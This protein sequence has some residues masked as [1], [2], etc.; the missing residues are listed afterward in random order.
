[1]AAVAVPTLSIN[2]RRVDVITSVSF[3]VDRKDLKVAYPS[4][5]ET[6]ADDGDAMQIMVAIAVDKTREDAV[7]VDFCYG[8]MGKL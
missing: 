3:D 2:P 7:M 1:M 4:G 8:L 6:K 5:H